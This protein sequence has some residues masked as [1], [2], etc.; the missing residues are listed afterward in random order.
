MIVQLTWVQLVAALLA[1]VLTG[2]ILTLMKIISMR[3]VV[4]D[5]LNRPNKVYT[6]EE[7]RELLVRLGVLDEDGN[8]RPP[9]QEIFERKQ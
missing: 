6:K 9:W 1:S 5:I 3:D 8:I 2:V 4:I 7:A